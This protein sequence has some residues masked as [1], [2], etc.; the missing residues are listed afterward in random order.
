MRYN[1]T[2]LCKVMRS[3]NLSGLKLEKLVYNRLKAVL[4]SAYL[5][6]PYYRR[7]MKACGYH[8]TKDY[9]GPQDLRR[10]TV[11]TKQVIKDH[12]ITELVSE[13]ADLSNYISES[14]S[15]STGIP[16]R[17][18]RSTNERSIQIA[19]WLR[20]LFKNGY[21][22]RDKVFAPRRPSKI[23]EGKGTL[24]RIGLFRRLAVDY[25]SS[26]QDMV[27]AFLAYKP[28]VLYGA[29]AHL[30]LMALEMR[31]RGIQADGLKLLV[32]TSEII[33]DSTRQLYR[34]QFGIETIESYGSVEMGTM[35]YETKEHDGLHLCED[36]TYFEFVDEDGSPVGP[37]QTGRIVVTDLTNKVMPFIRYDQ[38]DLISFEEGSDPAGFPQRKLTKIIGRDNDFVVLPGDI[39]IARQYFDVL[40][41]KYD[42]IVQYQVIQKSPDMVQVLIA[43][44]KIYVESIRGKLLRAL[45][46]TFPASISLEIAAVEQIYPDSS[47]KVKVIISEY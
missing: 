38:G 47:G 12:E 9:R 8:P 33:H 14:T 37:G 22:I 44:D 16:I 27:N 45:K 40:I 32:A 23:N 35:A 24:Q 1:P 20:V 30:D 6:V 31:R 26:P 25:L 43:A 18:Y 21:S 5:H 2:A 19:R 36:L 17:V 41:K 11:T 29:R 10:L 46:E 42:K 3:A 4:V 28:D 39:L 34:D 7:M 13:G 15:G